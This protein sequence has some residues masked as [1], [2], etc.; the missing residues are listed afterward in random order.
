M[1]FN[2]FIKIIYERVKIIIIYSFII[3]FIYSD[4]VTMNDNTRQGINFVSG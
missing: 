1:I 4:D 2:P 3:K